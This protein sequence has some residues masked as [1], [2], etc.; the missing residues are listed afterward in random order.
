MTSQV[1]QQNPDRT[2]NTHKTPLPHAVAQSRR[3]RR[4]SST[5]N[6]ARNEHTS[7]GA[8]RWHSTRQC[9]RESTS[10]NNWKGEIIYPVKNSSSASNSDEGCSNI[11]MPA[12]G[13]GIV[14]TVGSMKHKFMDVTLSSGAETL[15]AI[16]TS[17]EKWRLLEVVSKTDFH[18][19]RV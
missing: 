8:G 2:E 6:T 19:L 5:E 3:I 12:R 7:T 10:F 16:W 14:S 9:I 1:G 4:R 18:M 17:A 15:V 13:G 11:L